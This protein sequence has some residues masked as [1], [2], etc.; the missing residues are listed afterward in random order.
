MDHEIGSWKMVF[1]HGPTSW[2]NFHSPILFLKQFTKFL[3]PSPG[4]HRKCTKRNDRVPKS[5]CACFFNRCLKKVDLKE[6]ENLVWPF[7]CLLLGF[8][9]VHF[10]LKCVED[11]GCK[12]S[13]NKKSELLKNERFNM[14]MFNVTYMWHAPCVVQYIEHYNLQPASPCVLKFLS[15]PQKVVSIKDHAH[16]FAPLWDSLR[17][18]IHNSIEMWENMTLEEVKA[19]L[20]WICRG[21]IVLQG[22][23]MWPIVGFQLHIRF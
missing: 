14:Y 20:H 3:G 21:D 15:S 22:K 13:H 2:S 18:F 9:C 6:E 1:F 11:V 4:V 19:R 7:S 17:D 23:L 16:S 10:L 8:T 5:E 12:S